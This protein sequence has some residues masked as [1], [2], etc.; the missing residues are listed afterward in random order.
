MFGVVPTK[1]YQPCCPRPRWGLSISNLSKKSASAK[2]IAILIII[3]FLASV[4]ATS[5]YLSLKPPV[6]PASPSPS[7]SS[8]ASASPSEHPIVTLSP[9]PSV[10]PTA[11]PTPSPTIAPLSLTLSD[12]MTQN[13]VAADVS[14]IGLTKI[15]V[16]LTSNTEGMIEVTVSVGTLFTAQ[17]SSTQN[18]VIVES[19]VFVLGFRGDQVSVSVPAACA[20][21][22]LEQP[23][24][25][26]VFSAHVTQAQGDLAALLKLA[27]FHIAT[28]R[29]KQFA[30]WTLT[31]NPALDDSWAP[32]GY[33][34]LG[35]DPATTKYPKSKRS[36]NKQES[37]H[38]IPSTNHNI[39]LGER[40]LLFA[41]RQKK[42]VT[43]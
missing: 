19:K 1:F 6:S 24:S 27:D 31:D 2:A 35:Q 5:Y 30:V 32:S 15:N 28:A 26:D 34:T 3:A 25:L 41:S 13:L 23:S 10:T 9:S 18:M 8:A 7:A 21:M 20:T 40:F 22:H 42:Q 14:G 4:A 37:K 11:L 43:L 12:A 17:S 36:S 29:V 33:D 39:E 16:T 38:T